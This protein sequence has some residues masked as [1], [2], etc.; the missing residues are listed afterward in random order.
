MEPRER[1]VQAAENIVQRPSTTSR[2]R[3]SS[4]RPIP[5]T[6]RRP[7]ATC[8]CRAAGLDLPAS[9]AP[10]RPAARP[11]RARRRHADPARAGAGGRRGLPHPRP[12]ARRARR[13]HR[14]GAAGRAGRE[15]PRPDGGREVGGRPGAARLSRAVGRT[16]HVPRRRAVHE[17]RR[18]WPSTSRRPSR[19]PS[20]TSAS[21]SPRRRPSSSTWSTTTG[22]L[23]GVVPLRRLLIA[24]PGTRILAIRDERRRQ[25]DLRDGPRG[26]GA[27]RR[28][29]RPRQ[30]AGGRRPAPAGRHD[31]GRRRH[32][33]R[34]RGGLRGHLPHRRLRRLRAGA[35]LARPGGPDA[36][37]VDPDHAGSSRWWPGSSSTTSTRRWP[38]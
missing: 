1:L 16:P 20:S 11:L 10:S 15:D 5:P 7:S 26:G 33:H 29:V 18:S 28:Q 17:P 23:V 13:R 38:R 31:H 25:R 14:R 4:R 3:A 2:D 34:R 30:R 8:R 22:H 35:P 27:G 19:T 24:D 9:S 36:A 21:R 6:S 37:A 12:D 32:R